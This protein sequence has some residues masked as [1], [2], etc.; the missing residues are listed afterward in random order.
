MAEPPRSQSEKDPET[1]DPT[2]REPYEP[3]RIVWTEP[4]APTTFGVSCAKQ[5]GDC[6]PFPTSA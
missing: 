4:Y 5:P 2:R 3:P 1:R 6:E